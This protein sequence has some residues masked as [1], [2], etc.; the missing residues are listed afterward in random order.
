MGT[1][2]NLTPTSLRD[3]KDCIKQAK[4]DSKKSCFS[5]VIC[6]ASETDTLIDFIGTF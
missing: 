3:P 6:S 2:K 4:N 1:S 5:P